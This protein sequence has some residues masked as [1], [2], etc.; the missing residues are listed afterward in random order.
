MDHIDYNCIFCAISAKRAPASIV[1]ETENSI[2]FLD[3]RP[4]TRG[5]VLVIPKKHCRNLFDLDDG[6]GRAVTSAARIVA[7]AV[8]KAF[9]ADGMNLFQSSERAAGQEVFHFHF[10][11]VPR[12]LDDGLMARDSDDR[13]TRWRSRINL[14]PLEFE[15]IAD[16]I[17]AQIVDD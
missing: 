15:S 4:I 8:R 14:T 12:F 2:A 7:R 17:R 6:S 1:Y 13:M 5:H 11:L 3:N 9:S 16:R 10:H